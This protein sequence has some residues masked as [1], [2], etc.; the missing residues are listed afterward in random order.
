MSNYKKP[1]NIDQQVDYLEQYKNVTY[2]VLTKEEAKEFLFRYNY[3]NVITPFKHQFALKDNKGNV[4]KSHDKHVYPRDIEFSE[5]YELY[6]KERSI[7][8]TIAKNVLWFETQFKAI[9]AYRILITFDI[10]TN[11][12]AISFLGSIELN[13]NNDLRL[14]QGRKQH[15]ISSIL[16]LKSN[17]LRYHDIYCFFDRLTL[18]ES[19]NIY[20]GLDYKL[21]NTIFEDCKSI[22]MHFGVDK[23]PDF[24]S[25]IFTL[26]S[27]RNCVMHCNSLE[28]L[29]RFYN[30]TT[31]QLRDSTNRKRFTSMIAYLSKEK[32]YTK[33]V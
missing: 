2:N 19:L 22:N 23:T 9:L 20:Y 12:Q 5:Y 14:K 3:I 30:P 4:I 31:K 11:S 29:I 24:I 32:D 6:K 16:N 25:K 33:L 26:V 15:M 28:I 10:R 7:Y 21:Q 8:P 27:V 18:G 17:I 13:I 1:R